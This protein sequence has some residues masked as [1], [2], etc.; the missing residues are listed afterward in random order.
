M[1]FFFHTIISLAIALGISTTYA[2]IVV[3]GTRIVYPAGQKEVSVQLNNRGSL[4]ALAQV[5]LE[6]ESELAH[7]T[8][9]FV[10][11]PPLSRVEP[12]TGQTIRLLYTGEPLV[13][14][15]ESLFYFILLDIPPKPNNPE[16]LKN[17]LQIS[18]QSKLKLFFRPASLANSDPA[19]ALEQVKW[20]LSTHHNQTHLVIDNPTP[21]H[22]T[23]RHIDAVIEGKNYILNDVP[24]IK[25]F[26]DIT[27]AIVGATTGQLNK[28]GYVAINDYGANQQGEVVL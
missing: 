4:P 24:M 11:T 26:T 5:W 18:L 7:T 22:I 25:P 10:I 12:N 21:F 9:P 6:S 16:E 20:S 8:I 1:R 27:V 13:E 14:D 28:V 17:Y 2:N 15:R 19:K 23:F 3:S